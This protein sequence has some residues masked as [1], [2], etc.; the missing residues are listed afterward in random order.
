MQKI[1]LDMMEQTDCIGIYKK[2][3]KVIP[4][5]TTIYSMPS[6]DKNA[7]YQK[8]A[9][10]YDIHFIFEDNLPDIDFYT[11]PRI[12]IMAADSHGGY[13]GT[14][15]ETCDLESDAPICYIDKNKTCHLIAENGKTFLKTVHSWKTQ[16]KPC[17][18][19]EF[20]PSKEEAKKRHEFLDIN[21]EA[22]IKDD[23]V[24]SIKDDI[25]SPIE[26]E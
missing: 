26:A 14:I 17:E 2:D 1:Y 24:K 22:A 23:I 19:I 13:I 20:F 21:I 15:G 6:K 4:A 10:E 8:F 12:D 9:D 25:E 18:G 16:L 3:T 5:G 7:E 11:I